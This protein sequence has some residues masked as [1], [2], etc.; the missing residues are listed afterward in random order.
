MNLILGAIIVTV[1]VLGGFMAHGGKLLAIWQ[2]FEVV[3]ICG[4]ALGA[5]IISNSMKTI[6]K[7]FK[8][9]PGLLGGPKYKKTHYLDL[10]ALLYDLFTKARKEGLMGIEPD[11][12]EPQESA[13]FQ[14]YPSILKDHHVVEFISDY[15]RLVVS[16]SMNP[17]ELDN[18]MDIELETHHHEVG[19]PAH[20]VQ[21]VADALPAFGIVA[22]VLGIVNTMD[23]L[24]GP[25]EEIGGKVAAALVGTF[26]GILLAYGFVGPMSTALERRAEDEAKFYACLK[27][28]ILANVQGYS[29]QVA[30]EFGRKTMA[31]TLRPSFQE[32]EQH[33]RGTKE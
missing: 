16:G 15:M 31:S 26:L 27:A 29:P 2:P 3:I 11:I 9:I 17:F 28:C 8:G 25:I 33:L 10:L 7:V 18:L 5:F 12:E 4:A 19:E 23:S 24:G 13:I 1:S 20:A 14:K 32:L 22:A 6:M 21:R 30:V